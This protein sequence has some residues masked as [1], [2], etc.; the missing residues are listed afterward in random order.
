MDHN[1]VHGS[2]DNGIAAFDGSANNTISFNKATGNVPVDC[3]DETVG[4]GTAGTANFWTKN[5]G[6]TQNRPG[7]CKRATTT[8]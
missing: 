8:P 1:D 2:L 6:N 4:S 3:Y 7:L 5:M